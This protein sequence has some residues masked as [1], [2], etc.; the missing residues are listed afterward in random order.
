MSPLSIIATF[1]YNFQLTGWPV[2]TVSAVGVGLAILLT[3]WLHLPKKVKRFIHMIAPILMFGCLW[4]TRWLDSY[5]SPFFFYKYY[6]A[7]L[8]VAYVV[9][10]SFG[11]AFCIDSAR[12]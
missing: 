8:D 4:L 3:P 5:G 7:Q 10:Y 12:A 11:F 6:H 1:G 2:W 9:A